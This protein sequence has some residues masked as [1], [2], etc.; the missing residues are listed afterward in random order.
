M[1]REGKERRSLAGCVAVASGAHWRRDCERRTGEGGKEGGLSGEG[2][3][4]S[5]VV[6]V[7]QESR[8]RGR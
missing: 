7:R 4:C 2:G 5:S 8:G 1:A 6:I 3:E